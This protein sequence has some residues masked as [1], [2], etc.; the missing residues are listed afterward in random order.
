MINCCSEHVEIRD[1][2][3]NMLL[4]NLNKKGKK[5]EMRRYLKKINIVIDLFV[6]L[7]F[8]ESDLLVF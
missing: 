2:S 8:F 6:N 5:C 1:F 4:F 7:T 3:V